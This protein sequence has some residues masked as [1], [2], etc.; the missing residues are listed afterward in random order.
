V[1]LGIFVAIALQSD[2]VNCTC[3]SDFTRQRTGSAPDGAGVQ[4]LAQGHWDWKSG[5][6]VL[7]HDKYDCRIGRVIKFHFTY[8][9]HLSKTDYKPG[10][11]FSSQW[12]ENSEASIG[13]LGVAK[14]PT[15]TIQITME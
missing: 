9:I 10:H 5:L 11:K 4:K 13:L 1:P 6:R 2:I 15:S 8:Y 7:M 3:G 14:R 12:S